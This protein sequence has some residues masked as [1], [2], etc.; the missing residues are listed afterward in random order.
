MASHSEIVVGIAVLLTIGIIWFML[1]GR[2]E[3]FA[4][5]NLP[6]DPNR[7]KQQPNLLCDYEP[8]QTEWNSSVNACGGFPGRDGPATAACA[9]SMS[10]ARAVRRLNA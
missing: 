8:T 4:R 10:C 2:T 5:S 7:L 1:S 6:A 3:G 9:R